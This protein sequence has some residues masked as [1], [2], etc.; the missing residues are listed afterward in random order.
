M[1]GQTL[2]LAAVSRDH[3]NIK[4]TGILA[5][6]GN[7]FSV[8]REMRICRLAL[9][10]RDAARPAARARHHPNI[11]RVGKSDLR[12]AHRWGAQQTRAAGWLS[13]SEATGKENSAEDEGAA[14]KL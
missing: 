2:R 7:P 12:G 6:K 5:A 9:E 4:V 10:A 3:V 14:A 13:R 1:P 8:R 11:L